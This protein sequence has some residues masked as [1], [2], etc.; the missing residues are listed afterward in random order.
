[1]SVFQLRPGDCLLTP[2]KIEA[3]LT[4]VDEVRCTTPHDQ[5]VYALAR[6]GG[7]STY[8]PAS[9]LSSFANAQCLDRFAPYVGV[10]YQ[11]SSLYFTYLLPSV[12]S[13]AAGDRTVVCVVETVGKPLR[14]SVEGS[15]L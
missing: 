8:P 1:M 10:P 5:Q 6:D 14:R 13:W 12:R 3:E 7:G 4:S 9:T 2:K 15:K 11:D